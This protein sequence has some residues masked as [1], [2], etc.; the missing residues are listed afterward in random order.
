MSHISLIR[1]FNSKIVQKCRTIS[2]TM[3]NK[4][5]LLT[6][7]G[8]SITLS[9]VGDILQ[10]HYEIVTD[11]REKWDGLRTHHMSI[12][13]LTVG[14][15]CHNW[16]KV[17]DK[18]LPG[19]T[20]KIVLKKV[21]IDQIICSPICITAFFLTLGYLENSSWTEVKREIISKGHR[22]YVAEWIIWP[23]AQIINFYILP[24]RFRVLYDNTISL[25]YDVYTSY[26]KH[27]CE[28]EELKE[29]VPEESSKSVLKA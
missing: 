21:V 10:Q 2:G 12:S 7:V 8:I 20:L 14:I 5:L 9:G 18:A 6:N 28:S 23:P 17:L 3:F 25:G 29:N 16:Y 15:I 13:G 4:Y 27:D 1:L 26:V 24:T 19:R 11:K 22:L